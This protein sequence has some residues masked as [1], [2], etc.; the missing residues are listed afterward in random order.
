MIFLT[1]EAKNKCNTSFSRDFDWAIHFLIILNNQ[2]HLQGQNVNLKVISDKIYFLTSKARNA[3]NTS[4]SWDFD[5]K[6]HS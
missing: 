5:R 3:C 1:K 6:I 4:F 2:S